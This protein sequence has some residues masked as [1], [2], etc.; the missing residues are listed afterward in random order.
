MDDRG[1][2]AATRI[3]GLIERAI[4]GSGGALGGAGGSSGGRLFSAA[5]CGIWVGGQRLYERYAGSLAPEE[6]GGPVGADSLFDLAS[7]TKPLCTAILAM[8]A[9]E[10]GLF[11]LDAT[12]GSILPESAARDV[13][14]GAILA[15]AGGLQ[16]GPALERHFPD[17]SAF[18]PARPGHAARAVA[19]A[20]RE[21]LSLAPVEPRGRRVEYSCTGY[22]L[23]GLAL[24]LI[25]G[26]GLSELF[27][28]Q[29]ATPLDLGDAAFLPP[30][31]LRPR[32][33]ATELCPWR[34]RRLRGE[35]HDESAFCVGGAAGNAG[36]FAT[37]RD[38]RAIAAIFLN[39]GRGDGGA[40][41][42]P[43]V[44]ILSEESVRLMTVCAAEGLGRRRALG[45]AMHDDETQ[46]GPSWPAAAF[47]HTGYTG[48]SVFVE[49]GRRLLA[50]ALTN[51]VYYGRESTATAMSAFRK[52]LHGEALAGFGERRSPGD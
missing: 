12:L 46:D 1:S 15:H 8:R 16:A 5:A 19:T 31:E 45:F 36:L 20:E 26:K 40:D 35:V 22:M 38:L 11:P 39:G 10:A 34:G 29:I 47:G 23:L 4:G 37:L 43:G 52:E 41:G 49:P 30:P 24:R 28:D 32:I 50:I 33:A 44:R 6:G 3:D 14:L 42:K 21:L 7:L 9:R 48:T 25:A 13:P 17:A 27:R 2:E 18:E 51:R